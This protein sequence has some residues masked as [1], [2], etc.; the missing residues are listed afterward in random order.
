MQY[1]RWDSTIVNAL[2]TKELHAVFSEVEEGLLIKSRKERYEQTKHAFQDQSTE[3]EP[4][5]AT[6]PPGSMTSFP[7]NVGKPFKAV[8][9]SF[10]LF[11]K[12]STF[13]F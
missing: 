8:K 10:F 2:Q 13:S 7:S 11:L 1:R 9:I 4:K 12:K 5:G 6:I 3:R